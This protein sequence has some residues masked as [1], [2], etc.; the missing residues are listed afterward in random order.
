MRSW[1]CGREAGI[2]VAVA[3][4]LVLVLMML[5]CAEVCLQKSYVLNLEE[6]INMKEVF[7]W[8]CRSCRKQFS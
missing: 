7:R 5:Q 4:M 8:T 2:L 1:S 6:H 3:E